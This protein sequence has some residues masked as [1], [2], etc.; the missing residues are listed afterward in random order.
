M[1]SKLSVFLTID[2]LVFYQYYEKYLKE[3]LL[4]KYQFSLV[5]FFCNNDTNFEKDIGKCENSVYKDRSFGAL[6]KNLPKPIYSLDHE[7]LTAKLK[8][9]GVS[10]RTSRLIHGY[11]SNSYCILT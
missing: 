5:I 2:Q 1:L 3:Y 8:A 7:L 11:I 9:Y 4:S 6:L 10:L